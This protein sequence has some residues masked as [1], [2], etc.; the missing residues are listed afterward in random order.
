MK[1]VRIPLQQFFKRSLIQK[2]GGLWPCE[3]LAT[4]LAGRREKGANSILRNRREDKS[5]EM[6]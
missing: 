6:I 3:T 4:V 2:G 1:M 5:E